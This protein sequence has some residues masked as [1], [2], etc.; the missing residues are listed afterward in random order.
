MRDQCQAHCK[1]AEGS[2][3]WHSGQSERL[4]A[5]QKIPRSSTGEEGG[6]FNPIKVVVGRPSTTLSEGASCRLKTGLGEE[7][8]LSACFYH[9]AR[10]RYIGNILHG[11]EVHFS[12]TYHSTLEDQIFHSRAKT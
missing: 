7:P 11:Y 3:Q 5:I 1:S 8:D 6:T 4:E 9:S 10:F 12:F 2:S